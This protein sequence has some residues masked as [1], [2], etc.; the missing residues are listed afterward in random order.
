[1]SSLCASLCVRR[2]P[3]AVSLAGSPQG[4]CQ[5]GATA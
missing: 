3:G 4:A 2:G 5:G 1:M